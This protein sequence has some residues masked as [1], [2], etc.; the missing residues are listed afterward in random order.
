MPVVVTVRPPHREH[1]EV[2]T[3]LERLAGEL[4]PA[5]HRDRPL[6][7]EGEQR[8]DSARGAVVT[9]EPF[10]LPGRVGRVGRCQHPRAQPPQRR[11]IRVMHEETT[12]CDDESGR[13]GVELG[14]AVCRLGD[15]RAIVAGM[16]GDPTQTLE[17][18]HERSRY[19]PFASF[20]PHSRSLTTNR[21]TRF[22]DVR[23]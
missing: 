3:R 11:A 20:A 17:G 6:V 19:P 13:V 1:F 22:A 4:G 23:S 21:D 5:Q 16:P 10:G 18:L 14:E 7:R 9:H 15:E 12:A 2:G 8:G